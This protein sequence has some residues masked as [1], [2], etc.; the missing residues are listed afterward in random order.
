MIILLI[1]LAVL[2]LALV[3]TAVLVLGLSL[4]WAAGATVLVALALVL[5]LLLRR[6][7]KTSSKPQGEVEPATDSRALASMRSAVDRSLQILRGSKLGGGVLALPWYLVVGPAYAG[8]TA[9]LRHCGLGFPLPPAGASGR[10]PPSTAHSDFWMCN[11]AVLLDT[12]GRYFSDEA[13]HPEWLAFLEHVRRS[14][15]NVPVDGV[16]LALSAADLLGATEEGIGALGKAL[17]QRLDEVGRGMDAVV[18]VYLVVTKADRL[19]GFVES[20]ADFRKGDRSQVWGFTFD[21]AAGLLPRAALES[22]FDEWVEVAQARSLF[23]L[24]QERAL[25]VRE[26]IYQLPQQLNALRGPLGGLAEQLLAPSVFQDVPAVRGVFFTSACQDGVLADGVM[27]SVAQKLGLPAEQPAGAPV[28]QSK[29][30]FIHDLI[31]R[32]AVGDVGLRR[33]SARQMRRRQWATLALVAATFALALLLTLPP[34][35]AYLRNRDLL[36]GLLQASEAAASSSDSVELA[37]ERMAP[38]REQLELLERYQAEGPPLAM[39][40]GMYQGEEVLPTLSTVFATAVRDRLLAPLLRDDL[41]RL[42]TFSGKFRGVVPPVDAGYTEALGALKLHLLLSAPRASGEPGLREA[43]QKWAAGRLMALWRRAASEG[44]TATARDAVE[45]NL[46]LYLHLVAGE[47]AFGL[48]RQKDLVDRGRAT[49]SRAPYEE[50]LLERLVAAADG[51][52]YD[53]DLASLLGPASGGIRWERSVRGAFTRRGWEEVIRGRLD[54]SDEQEDGWVLGDN[55]GAQDRARLQKSYFRRYITE[56][57]E[58]LA[59]VRIDLAAL[60]ADGPRSSAETLALLQSLTRGEPTPLSRLWKTV[61]T[62]VRLVSEAEKGQGTAEALKKSLADKVKTAFGSAPGVAGAALAAVRGS[63]GLGPA[64]VERT[65]AGFVGFGVPAVAGSDPNA[66][67]ASTGLDLY[68]EQLVA[69]RDALQREADNPGDRAGLTQ[70]ANARAKVRSLIDGQEVGWRQTLNALLWPLLEAIAQTSSSAAAAEVS[71]LWC[72]S[73]LAPFEQALVRSYPFVADG[74]DA[75]MAD[76]VEFFRPETG[77]LWGFVSSALKNDVERSGDRYR[78]ARKLGNTSPAFRPALIEFLNRARDVTSAMFPPSG[79]EPSIPLSVS[80]RPAENVAGSVLEV[81]GQVIE[82]RNGPP[83]WHPIKWPNP[84]QAGRSVVRVRPA[85]GGE[86]ELQKV[87][88]WSFFRLLGAATVRQVSDRLF[89][90][91]WHFGGAAADVEI[92]L[93]PG[94]TESPFF[95]WRGEQ[96]Q[97]FQLFREKGLTLPREIGLGPESC[98]PAR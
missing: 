44:V 34:L 45:R 60:R 36:Q 1:G 58:F 4:L 19:P 64:D 33:P 37:M 77:I 18:P 29:S 24:G 80:I 71:A 26:R 81:D 13:A 73:V 25:P 22:R 16:L 76:F 9:L 51:P 88:E 70:L 78:F 15:S 50:L 17:R 63:E 47:P 5:V 14:R 69:V 57:R 21:D 90:A 96:K 41:A 56:W 27:A 31:A 53:L 95:G 23:R 98:P 65:F 87:G 42:A 94:R 62:N 8:K 12:S 46:R 20:F 86:Q 7:K 79:R 30:F 83:E 32:V 84:A 59:G 35:I 52:A 61:A 82:Y 68:L 91:N 74:P 49:L 43:E 55:R 97:L 66:K 89:V 11:E 39:R 85:H 6:K 92:E 93:R 38:V 10:G 40:F 54:A 75:P 48:A 72:S 2:L 28:A 67:P 3:W